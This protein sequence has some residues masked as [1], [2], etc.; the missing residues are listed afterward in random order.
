MTVKKKRPPGSDLGGRRKKETMSNIDESRLNVNRTTATIEELFTKDMRSRAV[1]LAKL[2]FHVFPVQ[3]YVPPADLTADAIRT[4]ERQAK[5]PVPGFSQKQASSD[6]Q[7]VYRLWSTPSGSPAHHNIGLAVTDDFFVLDIDIDKG[8]DGSLRQLEHKFGPLPQ[9]LRVRTRSGGTHYYF[10]TGGRKIKNSVSRI[11][12]GIDVRGAESR[13]YVL[14]PGSV[15]NGKSYDWVKEPDGHGAALDAM[16]E[17][18]SWLFDLMP[19]GARGERD[20]MAEKPLCALDMPHNVEVARRLIQE[21]EPAIEGA[22]GREHT[23]QLSRELHDVAISPDRQI[24]LLTAPFVKEGETEALSWNERC[25]PPWSLGQDCAREDDLEYLLQQAWKSCASR[26]GCKTEEGRAAS[27]REDFEPVELE[28]DGVG[29]DENVAPPNLVLTLADW[30]ERD[31]PPPDYICG[32]WLT[33]TSR[34]MIVAPTGLGKTMFALGLGMAIAGGRDFLRWHGVRPTRVLF[35]DGEMSNRLLKQR[36]ADETARLGF[37]PNSFFAL[38][39]EDCVGLKPLNTGPGQQFIE[40]VIKSCDGVD[41]IV[42]DNIMSLIAGDQK[43]EE[44]WRQTLPWVLSLTRR[45]VGQIWVHH[46]GH[47]E[48]RSYGTK[49]REWQ[50]DTV[51]FL[52]SV[53]RVDTDVSFQI[54]FSKA[55]ERTPRTRDE[56]KKMRVAL[57]DDRWAIVAGGSIRSKVA[58]LTRKFFEAL[59]SA[60]AFSD[61]TFGSECASLEDWR[62]ACVNAGL[63]E[64]EANRGSARALFS[65]A[66]RD[67]IASNWIRCDTPMASILPGDHG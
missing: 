44:G 7:L 59:R 61:A 41:L 64:P 14:A 33:T 22:G 34:A 28:G 35:I 15:I 51:L 19:T 67:L 57:L 8:G 50:M 32:N 43:D 39:R 25:S 47:D 48:S 65:R 3:A 26:P 11:A 13:G 37:S 42:F 12:K 5:T 2:R 36:L 1:N 9:T 23:M 46:T 40:S 62:A 31:L 21:T 4:A 24:E 18:P 38:S 56:F 16:A 6:P 49:T 63:I 27:A 10:W 45:S 30:A 20:P 54:S 60:A 17:A 55:R 29:A 58:P 52:E 53:K 66:K